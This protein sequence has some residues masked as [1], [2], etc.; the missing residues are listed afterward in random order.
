MRAS[1]RESERVSES[2][3]HRRQAQA[4][5]GKLEEEAR[6][7]ID[8]PMRNERAFRHRPQNEM[9]PMRVGTIRSRIQP[10]P[11]SFAFLT[12]KRSSPIKRRRHSHSHSYGWP[13]PSARCLPKRIAPRRSIPSMVQIT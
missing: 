6:K 12:H 7:N 1:E 5:R 10:I 3:R 9:N 4:M 2:E 8:A 13:W 11:S